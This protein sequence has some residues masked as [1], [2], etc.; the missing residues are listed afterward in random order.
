MR[1]L[2]CV[3]DRPQFCFRST[4]NSL[5]ENAWHTIAQLSES[6]EISQILRRSTLA[7]D[8]VVE[9]L[10]DGTRPPPFGPAG[11]IGSFKAASRTLWNEIAAVIK[12]RRRTDKPRFMFRDGVFVRASGAE[13][14]ADLESMEMRLRSTTMN[15]S[16][17]DC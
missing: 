5:P 8:E 6:P 15:A 17:R 14:K 13:K 10:I 4:H 2:P 12:S 1:Y 3:E 16:S 7:T 11:H 9:H